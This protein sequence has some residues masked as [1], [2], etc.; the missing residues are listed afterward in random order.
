MSLGRGITAC[1]GRAIRESFINRGHSAPLMPSV[2]PLLNLREQILMKKILVALISS[3][4]FLLPSTSALGQVKDKQVFAVVPAKHQARLIK[5]FNLYVEYLRTGQGRKLRKLYV[6][7]NSQIND[8]DKFS[9]SLIELKPVSIVQLEDDTSVYKIHAYLKERVKGKDQISEEMV[10]V[11]AT[12]RNDDWYF[13]L[14][15][16]PVQTLPAGA[17]Y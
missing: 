15:M 11:E 8:P 12:L 16:L 14:I 6:Y 4:L 17:D 10:D 5:R 7:K 9:P 3:V 2:R 13:S 1:S